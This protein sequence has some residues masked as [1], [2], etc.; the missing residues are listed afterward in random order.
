MPAA[1]RANEFRQNMPR[2][3]HREVQRDTCGNL[4]KGIAISCF[5]ALIVNKAFK[6]NIYGMIFGPFYG[7]VTSIYLG[8][9]AKKN[10]FSLGTAVC[11]G[12]KVGIYG[13]YRYELSYESQIY[14]VDKNSSNLTN[15]G[16]NN[17]D[18]MLSRRNISMQIG[19]A[20]GALSAACAYKFS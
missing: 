16:L 10:G 14:T 17:V 15:L 12:A 7:L 13:G 19:A 5:G 3:E 2:P 9:L 1:I 6:Y 8:T 20:A 4:F 11:M 18:K